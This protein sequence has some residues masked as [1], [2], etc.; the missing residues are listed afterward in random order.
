[1]TLPDP[2][3]LDESAS[4][5]WR[6]C[7]GYGWT[8]SSEIAIGGIARELHKLLDRQSKRITNLEKDNQRLRTQLREV[9]TVL[10]TTRR[11]LKHTLFQLGAPHAET[12]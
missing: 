11:E 5:I 6:L 7:R 8:L 10:T 12:D 1:M 2:D 4:A 3:P 9:K